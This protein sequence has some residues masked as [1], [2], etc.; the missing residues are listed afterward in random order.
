MT[1]SQGWAKAPW[2]VFW[3]APDGKRKEK[4][5]GPGK[6]GWRL[7]QKERQRIHGELITGTYESRSGSAWEEFRSEFDR[8]ILDL[9]EPATAKVT[10]QSL[11]KF[12]RIVKPHKLS[13][14]DRNC[15][16]CYVAKRKTE[17]GKKPDSLVS[18]CTINKEL[19]HLKVVL[20]KAHKWGY[21][22]VVPD[23]EFVREIG[24]VPRYVTP[25]HFTAMYAACDHAQRQRV[26][27]YSAVQALHVP[28]VLRSAVGRF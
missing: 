25:E 8:L 20:R 27:H 18:A 16:A 3:N 10:C 24:K 23:F 9:M 19:R 2:V 15:V 7:A 14:L 6:D 26:G 28:Q 11:E 13:A 17:P 22:P 12:E 21:L 5:C 4:S 1:A